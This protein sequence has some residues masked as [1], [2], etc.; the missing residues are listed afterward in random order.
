MGRSVDR[1]SDRELLSL[2]RFC[3][4]YIIAMRGYDFREGQVASERIRDK[5][6]AS[7][8]QGSGTRDHTVVCTHYPIEN[9]RV[10]LMTHLQQCGNPTD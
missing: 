9:R 8:L 1:S 7:G 10:F 4:G 6:A 5:I 2:C 3:Q